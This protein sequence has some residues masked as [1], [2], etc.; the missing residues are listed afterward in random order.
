MFDLLKY[1]DDTVLKYSAEPKQGFSQEGNVRQVFGEGG[2]GFKFDIPTEPL[3]QKGSII[4]NPG[5]T[6]YNVNMYSNTGKQLVKS[7]SV[8]EYGN[9]KKAKAAGEAFIKD[10]AKIDSVATRRGD[11]VRSY[12]NHLDNVGEFDGTEKLAEELKKYRSS[13]YD[14]VYEQIN[15]DFKNWKNGKFEVEGID[16]NKIP[17]KYK[18][19]ITNWSP[20]AVGPRTVSR[21]RQIIFLDGLNNNNDLTAEQARKVFDQEFKKSPFWN[22]KTF[23]QRVNQLTKLKNEGQLSTNAA[24]TTFKNYGVQK[25]T[26][27]TWLKKALGEQFNGNYE[28]FIKAADILEKKGKTNDAKRLY[29][30]AEKF[31]GPKGIFTK[32]PGNAEHPLSVIYGNTTDTLLKIDSLVKGD[33]NQFKKVL[34]DDPLRALTAEYNSG[35]V[36]PARQKQIEEIANA[37]KNFLNFLTSGSIEKGIVSPV[38]FKFGDKF[39][40]KS[41]VIPIDKLPKGFDFE[42]F[43]TKGEGYRNALIKKDLNLITKDGF[44]TRKDIFDENILKIFKNVSKSESKTLA[45]NLNKAGFKCKFD[46]GGL[47]LC[48]NPADYA[49]DIARQAKLAADKNPAAINK[50][51]NAGNIVRKGISGLSAT[52]VAAAGELLFAFPFAVMDYTDGLSFQ[53]IIGNATLGLFGETKNAE[54]TSYPGGYMALKAK[55]LVQKTTDLQDIINKETEISAGNIMLSPDD[56]NL[57]PAQREGAEK[58]VFDASNYYSEPDGY[59]RFLRDLDNKQKIEEK[60]KNKNLERSLE[61]EKKRNRS[62]EGLEGFNTFSAAYGGIANLTRTIPPERGPNPQGLASLKKYDK[63]Y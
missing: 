14:H 47:A 8:N 30:S 20:Q 50:F 61:R 28:R 27:S 36:T 39:E 56:M 63:Q 12:L 35:K 43:V 58:R 26:R 5:G 6:S 18:S 2:I 40:V 23:D 7:F 29:D 51:K 34:F 41:N 31:F 38:E 52:G 32:L 62:L 17:K 48:D 22:K 37:R 4:L 44:I 49:E 11:V 16:R 53:R 10:N 42:K 33:L 15:L 45:Q 59:E 19:I 54:I 13:T 25:G 21:G 60:I 55:N 46:N 24:G 9:L 1:I 57:L 3:M